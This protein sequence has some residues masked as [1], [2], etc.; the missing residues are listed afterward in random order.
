MSKK[1]AMVSTSFFSGLIWKLM[2]APVVIVGLFLFYGV[3]ISY[4]LGSLEERIAEL[5]DSVNLERLTQEAEATVNAMHA[6]MFRG[7]NMA[8]SK[9][10]KAREA[11]KKLTFRQHSVVK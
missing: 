8:M 11:A 1:S 5:N 7:V 6:A 4:S 10:E 2:I 3:F 9:D